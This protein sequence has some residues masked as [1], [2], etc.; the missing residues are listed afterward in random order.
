MSDESEYPC[1]KCAEPMRILIGGAGVVFK[2]EGWATTD[3]RGNGTD[4]FL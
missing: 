1:E 4:I 3:K 2:G